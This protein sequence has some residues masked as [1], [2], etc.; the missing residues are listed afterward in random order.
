VRLTSLK[1]TSDVTGQSYDVSLNDVSYV[2]TTQAMWNDFDEL[3]QIVDTSADLSTIVA[4]ST[5]TVSSMLTAGYV[6]WTIRG[7][8]LLSSLLANIPAWQLVNPLLVLDELFDEE[9]DFDDDE[10]GDESQQEAKK[11]ETMFDEE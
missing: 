8:Y 5:V 9:S 7:G 10:D 2:L 11:V 3:K 4:G 6:L 1:A